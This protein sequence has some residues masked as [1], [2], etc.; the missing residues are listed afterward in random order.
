MVRINL[1]PHRAEKRRIRQ[2]QFFALIGASFLLGAVVVGFGDWV[3]RDRIEFQGTRNTYLKNET[4]KLDKEIEEIQKLRKEI[5]DLQ[6]RKDVV[7][8]L[9]DARFNVVH[10]M[11]QILRILPEGVYLRSL[12]QGADNKISI[13]GMTQSNAR[14]STLMVAI[15]DSQWFSGANLI[16]IHS[17][18]QEGQEGRYSEFSLTF[19]LTNKAKRSG[20]KKK[21]GA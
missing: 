12:K 9:Q 13:V 3:L 20:K 6:K 14:V 1:L 15:E 2:L 4:A 11:D 16:E 19:D 5:D 10:L 18:G 17:V 21:G 8:N 7:D